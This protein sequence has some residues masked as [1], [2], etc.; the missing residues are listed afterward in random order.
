VSYFYFYNPKHFLDPGPLLESQAD[1][2]RKRKS[3]ELDEKLAG[4]QEI[5]HEITE[6]QASKSVEY[7][8]SLQK[9]RIEA[10]REILMLQEEEEALLLLLL[11]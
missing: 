4:Y 5:L 6:A 8:Q 7:E 10:A 9:K 3:E 2:I 11:N 1:A